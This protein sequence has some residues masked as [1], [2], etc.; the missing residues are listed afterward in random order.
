MVAALIVEGTKP[1]FVLRMLIVAWMQ[2]ASVDPLSVSLKMATFKPEPGTLF[3]HESG[4][5][6]AL[7]VE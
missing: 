7:T 3:G 6:T 4:A 1:L 5:V 2:S